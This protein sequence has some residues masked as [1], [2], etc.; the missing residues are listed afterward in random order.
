MQRSRLTWDKKASAHPA[1][2]DEGPASPAYPGKDPEATD[3]EN[4]DTSSWA[5]DPTKGPYTNSAHPATPDEGPASPAFKAAAAKYEKKAEICIRI[6]STMLPR[7]A[8]VADIEKQALTLMNLPDAAIVAA[9]RNLSA[10]EEVV[11]EEEEEVTKE[12]SSKTAS[13][14]MRMARIER[15]LIAMAEE[16]DEEEEEVEVE[17]SKKKSSEEELLATMLKEEGMDGDDQEEILASMLKEEGMDSEEEPHE[18][19]ACDDME[20]S[21]DDPMGVM[22]VE[23]DAEESMILAQL[24]GRSAGD[25]DEEEVEVEVESSKKASSR[26]ASAKP[27]PKKASASPR[28]LGTVTKSSSGDREI[29][30]LTNL[31]KSAPDVSRHF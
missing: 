17:S 4:G 10:G 24:Q 6:A 7:N 18:K 9:N 1:Y 26:T 13:L 15:I 21:F 12:S 5:E 31:W 14:E 30:Q 11:E 23:L 8:S 16:E 29:D 22:D 28:T 27:Q 20:P 2:P 3:Y 25:E 19:E